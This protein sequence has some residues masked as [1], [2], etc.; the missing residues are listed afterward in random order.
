[1]GCCLAIFQSNPFETPQSRLKIL[2]SGYLRMYIEP[3]KSLG[4]VVKAEERRRRRRKEKKMKKG[5][6]EFHKLPK[7]SPYRPNVNKCPKCGVMED[8]YNVLIF[9]CSYKGYW[10]GTTDEQYDYFV[11]KVFENYAQ[12]YQ[13]DNCDGYIAF[14]MR[15]RILRQRT[16]GIG[17]KIWSDHAISLFG[18]RENKM[19]D[20][21]N[22]DDQ[23][24]MKCPECNTEMMKLERSRTGTFEEKTIQRDLCRICDLVSIYIHTDKS[25]F[26]Y[27]T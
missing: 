21:K 23:R 17:Y 5:I 22:S 1:M 27:C 26:M 6:S 11:D 9:H 25:G 16:E 7:D 15:K 24:N 12:E 8:R 19:N 14:N 3:H 4:F 10:N 20:E 18:N 2:I 13:C